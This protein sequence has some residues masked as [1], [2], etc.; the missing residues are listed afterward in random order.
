MLAPRLAVH[1]DWALQPAR[2]LDEAMRFPVLDRS[3]AEGLARD[4]PLVLGGRGAPAAAARRHRGAPGRPAPGT[5]RRSFPLRRGRVPAV[6][7]GVIAGGR[8]W[9]RTRSW[10]SLP[11]AGRR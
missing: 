3:D 6:L 11:P 2:W 8:R 9:A 4:A 5:S 1:P 10:R 7:A